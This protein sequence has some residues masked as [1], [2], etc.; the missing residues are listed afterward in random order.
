MST[1]LQVTSV[2]ATREND[3]AFLRRTFCCL[4]GFLTS[5]MGQP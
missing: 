2:F 1:F 3:L 4:L 5:G